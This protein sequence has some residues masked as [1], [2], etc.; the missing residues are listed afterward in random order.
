MC[1]PLIGL[2]V[3]LIIFL[4]SFIFF[5][6]GLVGVIGA[7]GLSW[8][9][10]TI[11]ILIV[12]YWGTFRFGGVGIMGPMNTWNNGVGT[13]M[14]NNVDMNHHV[15]EMNNVGVPVNNVVRVNHPE[16]ASWPVES[17]PVGSSSAM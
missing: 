7:W 8:V 1:A 2:D 14:N 11:M 5:I 13:G 16:A 15:V 17:E 6:C 3:V 4:L 12:V 9:L 10:F